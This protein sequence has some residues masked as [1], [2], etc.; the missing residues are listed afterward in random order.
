MCI[1]PSTTAITIIVSMGGEHSYGLQSINK[2]ISCFLMQLQVSVED[3]KHDTKV[4]PG[5]NDIVVAMGTAS[6]GRAAQPPP[7]EK[8][9]HS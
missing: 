1:V 8:F 6:L 2:G 7:S 3:R 9:F 4:E 5:T